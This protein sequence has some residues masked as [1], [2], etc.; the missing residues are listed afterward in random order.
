LSTIKNIWSEHT[1]AFEEVT[2]LPAT[3]F[4]QSCTALKQ[5]CYHKI[6]D[7][8][9]ETNLGRS[10]ATSYCEKPESNQFW[11]YEPANALVVTKK[12]FM[13]NPNPYIYDHDY[14][15]TLT[16]FDATSAGLLFLGSGIVKYMHVHPTMLF[17]GGMTLASGA[18]ALTGACIENA[19]DVQEATLASI[20]G[21]AVTL[22]SLETARGGT[23]VMEGHINSN[24]N[25]SSFTK[26]TQKIAKSFYKYSGYNHALHKICNKS[27]TLT[28]LIENR[29]MVASG[30]IK[31]PLRAGYFASLGWNYAANDD[32]SLAL[33]AV[34]VGIGILWVSGDLSLAM[35]DEKFNNKVRDKLGMEPIERPINYNECR[36]FF[37]KKIK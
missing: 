23:F 16:S 31:A 14:T 24:D 11:S 35:M 32:A 2:K 12:H 34:G 7:L 33:N 37:N 28:D 3:S 19:E 21:L 30:L 13:E 18:V 6:H 22:S 25:P 27:E 36:L 4:I 17:Y 26:N 10:I 1:K 9:F 29:P 20:T 15:N 8:I 5:Q